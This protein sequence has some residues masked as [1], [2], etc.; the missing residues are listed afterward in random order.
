V[1]DSLRQGKYLQHSIDKIQRDLHQHHVRQGQSRYLFGIGATLILSGTLLLIN[2]PEWE[3]MPAWL[4]AAG[5][6][7]WLIGWRRSA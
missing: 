3:F 4:M 2:K 7:V 5:I 6:V 1:Y